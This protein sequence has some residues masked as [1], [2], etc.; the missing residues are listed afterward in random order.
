MMPTAAQPGGPLTGPPQDATYRLTESALATDGLMSTK[1]FRTWFAQR[2]AV[3]SY[4]VEHLPLAELVGWT[5]QDGTGNLVHESGRFYSI[6]GLAVDT[7]H[8][9]R[10]GWTQPIIVQPEIGILGILVK[11]YDGVLHCLMQAKMEPGNVNVI[12]LSPTVQATRSNYTRVHRGTSIPYLEYFVAPRRGR[13]LLDV[14]QSEQGAWFLHKRNRNIVVEVDED[15]P[16]REDFCW[17]TL[18]QLRELL[19]IDNLVNMDSRTV[20]SG[21]PFAAPTSYLSET[22]SDSFRGALTRSLKHRD[23]ALLSSVNVL[24]WF[25]EL[26]SRYD[27]LQRRIPLYEVDQWRRVA[28]EIRHE[29]DLYF[30]VI[31]VD[32]KASNREVAQ[33]TQPLLAPWSQGVL[34]LLTKRVDGELQVLVQARTEAG[35][36]DVVEMAATVHCAP[37]NYADDDGYRPRYLDYLLNVDPSRIRFDTIHSEEGGRLYQAENR[38]VII[39]VEE[40]F[41]TE[42]P[43]DFRWLTVRQLNELVRH[44]NYVNVELRSLLTCL[45]T[46]W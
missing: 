35:T 5:L 3:N 27:L 4:H 44:A 14:L 15:V 16:L 7:D 33:W 30:R 41:P 9:N 31:G 42:A 10:P 38:Y 45:H 25:T 46:L 39:E 36:F 23:G 43:D 13:V 12:Q 18:G 32:V 22:D 26:K 20:L 40:D 17:L 11:E 8:R 24:S 29:R 19:T 34:A 1:E 28:G 6:E 37:R 2:G 21:I